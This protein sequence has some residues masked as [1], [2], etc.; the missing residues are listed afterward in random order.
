M[1]AP[2]CG[3]VIVAAGMGARMGGAAPK[4]IR[5][6]AGRPLV[7]WSASFFNRAASVRE[8]VIVAPPSLTTIMA[9]ICVCQGFSRLRGIVA[10]GARRQDS[11]QAGVAALSKDCRLVAVHDAAR[12]FPP[13]NFEEGVQLARETGAAVFG[14]AVTDT[15][16]T[17]S[18]GRVT[19]TMPRAGVWA[20]QTPQIF[21]RQ[22]LVE[23]LR[24]CRCEGKEVTDDAAAVEAAGGTVCLVAGSRWNMKITFAEDWP[25]AEALAQLHEQPTPPREE[26]H[27]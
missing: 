19:G 15:L 25:V 9:S 7:L 6:L 27:L 5:P 1:M 17:A 10:G 12:P 2:D 18:D 22:M 23:A 26:L 8:M 20:V 24:H 3:V 13:V 21:R 4:Q 11:V 16:K 14:H